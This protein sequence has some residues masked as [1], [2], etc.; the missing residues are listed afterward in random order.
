MAWE[1]TFELRGQ[2]PFR[3]L[4]DLRP[5]DVK[6]TNFVASKLIPKHG[7]SNVQK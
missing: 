4:F 7:V 5:L 1:F 2:P 6:S 3:E